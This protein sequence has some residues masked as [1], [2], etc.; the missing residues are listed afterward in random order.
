MILKMQ[1]GKKGL[2]P[3]FMADLKKHFEKV[4][5]VRVSLLKASGRDRE[6]TKEIRDQIIEELGPKYTAKIIGFTLAI[7]K[8]RKAR[9]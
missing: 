3:E 6:S 5:N 9:R 7:K 8:W 2:T 1:I 4:E